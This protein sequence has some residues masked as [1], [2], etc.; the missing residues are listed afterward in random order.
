MTM[1]ANNE[2]V[3]LR[4]PVFVSD[5]LQTFDKANVSRLEKL[6]VSWDE[7]VELLPQVGNS[8]GNDPF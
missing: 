2:K 7:P 8:I 3:D 4:A 1:D 6:A 5:T